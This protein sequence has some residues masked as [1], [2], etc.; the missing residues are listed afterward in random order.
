[1]IV[2]CAWCGKE[3]EVIDDDDPSPTHGICKECKARYIQEFEENKQEKE[4]EKCYNLRKQ[5][6]RKQS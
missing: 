2:I 1:M 6:K 4:K 3:M 5:L